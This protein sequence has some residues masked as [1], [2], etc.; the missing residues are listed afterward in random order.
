MEYIGK[1]LEIFLEKQLM[2]TIISVVVMLS[3]NLFL[4]ENSWMINKLGILQFRILIFGLMFILIKLVVYIRDCFLEK[5]VIKKCEEKN[6]MEVLEKRKKEIKS[7]QELADQ[8]TEKER[9]LIIELLENGNKAVERFK[10]DAFCGVM[11]FNE[12]RL[13]YK[14]TNG[15]GIE[16]IKLKENIYEIYSY[17]YKKYGRIGNF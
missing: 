7:F 9:K 11:V 4:P 14:S 17:I 15:K 2:P 5:S 8:M 3:V 10:Y 6:K 12:N 13:F 1:A 16:V